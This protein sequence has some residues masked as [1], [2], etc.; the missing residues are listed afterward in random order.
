MAAGGKGSQSTFPAVGWKDDE[1]AVTIQQVLEVKDV[2]CEVPGRTLFEGLSFEVAY[3]ESVVLM[4]PSGVGKSTLLAAVLGIRPIQAGSIWV[5]GRR[6][7]GSRVSE[8]LSI[9]RH[10][11]GMVFQH[12]ELLDELSGAE[13]VSI[14]AML[15]GVVESP[16]ID[17]ARQLLGQF[18]VPAE[19]ET[20]S[21]S[22]GER[23]R[24]ALARA[25]ITKPA[26]LLAD[27]PTAALDSDTKLR[28]AREMFDAP[29]TFECGLLVATHDADIACLA[30]RV[31]VF[32]DLRLDPETA[33][34]SA[35]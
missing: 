33:S 21:L 9:R 24:T 6:M 22:G 5:T 8:Q 34:D 28:V 32:P 2:T 12:A 3:R 15:S 30:D 25:L 23:Q 19:T 4:G 14:P 26:L 27:E 1:I 13:N 31:I 20:S 11:I 29:R 18:G 7:D 17:R 16:A 35:G 10:S